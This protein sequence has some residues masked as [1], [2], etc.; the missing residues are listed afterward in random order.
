M[1]RAP[2]PSWL[3]IGAGALLLGASSGQRAGTFVGASACKLCHRAV[4]E[5]W[6]KTPH[7]SA[8]E[9]APSGPEGARCLACHATRE[10]ELEGVQ[11]ESCHGPGS[12]Y[13]APE[14]MID[15]EKAVMAGLVLPAMD[16]CRRCHENDEPDH[17]G[18]FV[19]PDPGGVGRSIHDM[20]RD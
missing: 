5:S 3:W 18:E 17:R 6:E 19:W 2:G 15:V 12:A 16:A 1:N 4:Y 11:C 14:V 7:R 8:S 20:K 10:R 13:S 9:K